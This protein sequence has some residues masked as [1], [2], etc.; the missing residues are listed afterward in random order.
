MTTSTLS[1]ADPLAGEATRRLAD[2]AV[3]TSGQDL[4]VRPLQHARLVVLDTVGVSLAAVGF[5]VGAIVTEHVRDLGGHPVAGV[6]GTDIKVSAPSAALANGTLA[7]GLDYDDHKHLSTHTLPAALAVGQMLGES[8]ARVLEAYVVGREVGA[9]LGQIIEAK[10]K[11][12]QGPTYR[13][14]YRVGVVGPI[15][16]AVSAGKLLDLSSAQMA[17]A[18]GLAASS[19]SGL[20]RNQGTMAK[21]L[22]AGNAAS[23]GVQSA[24][25][26]SR[27]FTADPEIL[28]APLGLVNAI[29][30]PGESDWA[31]LDALGSPFELEGHLAVKPFPSCSPSHMPIAAALSLRAEHGLDPETIE[32]IHA[33]LH[34]FSLLRV[35][36]QE[37]I[38][39]G[40]S[41]PYL[42][43]AAFLFGEIGPD[44]VGES[45]LHDDRVRALMAK[46]VQDPEAAPSGQPE[47]VTVRLTDGTVLRAETAGKPD[48]RDAGSITAKF[49]ACAGRVLPSAQVEQL[50]TTIA[51]LDSL[52]DISELVDLTIPA[53]P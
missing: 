25:L 21:A 9:R 22:H 49:V 29:C 2:F 24:L 36:P 15:A 27:G 7:H 26:A 43:A 32:S 52:A 28:E 44:Q 47:S 16:S 17:H 5:P 37:A 46:V 41:L 23:S 35:D 8:G 38:A 48:L 6:L 12:K 53:H 50:Q 19:S 40:Y 30:L 45:L 14:W 34:T 11:L 33:D 31:P 18:I 20:R 51:H 3:Q 10:R 13:G 1:A 42:L 4:P 39:T